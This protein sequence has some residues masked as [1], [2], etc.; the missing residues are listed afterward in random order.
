MMN[1]LTTIGKEL[2]EIRYELDPLDDAFR[3]L[4][5]KD[6]V[7]PVL[8]DE[9]LSYCNRRLENCINSLSIYTGDMKNID[10]YI[11]ISQAEELAL[12]LQM[13]LWGTF[14]VG[15]D[16]SPLGRISGLIPSMETKRDSDKIYFLKILDSV[17]G[18]LDSCG[19]E[20]I[21][22]YLNN[23]KPL[24]SCVH[25]AIERWGVILNNNGC[26]LFPEELDDAFLK[27][28]HKI[29]AVSI[30]PAITRYI[31]VLQSIVNNC[32]DDS[33]PGMFYIE[34]GLQQYVELVKHHT[35]E[36]SSPQE[37]HALGLDEVKRIHENMFLL[38]P[39]VQFCSNDVT[40][41]RWLSK[42]QSSDVYGNEEEFF[43]DFSNIINNVES[44]FGAVFNFDGI[45]AI[46]VK[47]IPPHLADSSPT[48]YY[49]PGNDNG[50]I[51]TLYINPTSML[52][53][54]KGSANAMIFHET[55]PGHHAQFEYVQK[56]SLPDYRKT[57]WFN[58]FIE[59]WALYVEDLAEELGLYKSHEQLKG[60]L[61]QEL[62]RAARLVV[63]TGLHFYGWT[64]KDAVDY[65]HQNTH[66]SEIQAEREINRYIEYPAQALSY[67]TGKFHI[68]TLRQQCILSMRSEFNYK[69]FH[70]GLLKHGVAPLHAIK[71]AVLKESYFSES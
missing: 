38:N 53:E 62:F 58:C 9:L 7:L 32:R 71:N 43:S 35:D 50:D 46:N 36:F 56:L 48:A 63:D 57:A 55:L 26:E 12:K 69:K 1:T 31:E 34:N 6:K 45:S 13:R 39:N 37:I 49:M 68:K 33:M 59:G 18:Y 27:A 16:H 24:A 11:L 28:C 54:A 5:V 2:L 61:L 65:L 41:N 15:Y 52:G 51:G 47:K 66:F 17:G 42:H 25:S 8:N 14:V 44:M 4:A 30:A 23:R 19:E 10:Y 67:A 64:K 3:V 40:F 60:K 70:E 29:Y 20:C 21:R 22:A